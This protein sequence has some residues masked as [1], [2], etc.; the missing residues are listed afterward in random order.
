[1]GEE[2]EFGGVFEELLKKGVSF[3]FFFFFW[4]SVLGMDKKGERIF[5]RLTKYVAPESNVAVVSEPAVKIKFAFESSRSLD[6]VVPFSPLCDVMYVM[7]SGRSVSLAKR[8]E[9]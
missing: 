8:F 2:G 9:T 6:N 4:F 1:M 3:G 7:K 5:I